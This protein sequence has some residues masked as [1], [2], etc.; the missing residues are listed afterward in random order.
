MIICVRWV[1][2]VIIQRMAGLEGNFHHIKGF[3]HRPK[4]MWLILRFVFLKQ[5]YD[6]LM[7]QEI[8]VSTFRIKDMGKH[9]VRSN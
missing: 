6:I 5:K 2:G 9:M 8:R 4:K 7:Y 3:S 1:L